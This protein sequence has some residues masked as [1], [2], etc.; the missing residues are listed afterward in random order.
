MRK[1]CPNGKI[2]I[3]LK[4]KEKK[5]ESNNNETFHGKQLNRIFKNEENRE[6]M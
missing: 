2:K 1:S 6:R 4:Y 5:S 3:T